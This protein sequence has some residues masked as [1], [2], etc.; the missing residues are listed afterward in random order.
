VPSANARSG[1]WRDGRAIRLTVIATGLL[2]AACAGHPN[3]SL[4]G[5]IGQTTEADTNR[6]LDPDSPDSMVTTGID[7]GLSLAG[8]SKRAQFGADL[9]VAARYFLGE[10]DELSDTFRIDPRLALRA[11][12]QGKTYAL[13]GQASVATR[14]TAFSRFDELGADPIDDDIDDFFSDTDADATQITATVGADLDLTLDQLNRVRLGMDARQVEFTG[15][16]AGLTPTRSI[17][18]T[19]RWSRQLT[20]TSTMILS[21]ALRH[22]TADD[23]ENRQSQALTVQA[24]LTHQR[25]PRHNFRI[26]GGATGVRTT[27]DSSGEPAFDIRF[28]G[29]AGFDYTLKTLTAGINLSQNVAPSSEEGALQTFT[30]L[31]GNLSYAVNSR[32]S[33]GAI[34]SYARRADL[35][36]GGDAD[37]L[38]SIG[39]TY[40]F[41]LTRDTGLSLGYFYRL[42]LEESGNADGHRVFLSISHALDF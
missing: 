13:N 41:A 33:L 38:L 20:Q 22:F 17:R 8:Q 25:T 40:N 3:W 10:T 6:D 4:N 16:D 19:A 42:N 2:L 5:R 35:S 27:S 23:D 30:R 14:S 24:G 34:A 28:T 1:G 21:T 32:Q 37:Q 18:S 31:T 11:G 29:G 9:D 36:G 12:Y 15:E 39:P 7:T 26:S